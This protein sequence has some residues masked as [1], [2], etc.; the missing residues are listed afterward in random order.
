MRFNPHV[1]SKFSWVGSGEMAPWLG[2]CAAF[3][4]GGCSVVSS[5]DQQR[6]TP[7]TL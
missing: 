4:E 1:F 3:A 2:V 6:V 7:N 5:K